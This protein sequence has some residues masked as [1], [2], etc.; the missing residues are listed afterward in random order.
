MS[1][2]WHED[3][4]GRYAQRYHD[5][6]AWTDYVSNREGVT[7]EDPR[8]TEPGPPPYPGTPTAGRT[9]ER[10][11]LGGPLA[12]IGGR[13]IDMLLVGVPSLLVSV[14]VFDIELDMETFDFE[15]FEL[16]VEV[17]VFSAIV[18]AIYETLMVGRFGRTVGKMAVGTEVVT[19]S[20]VAPSY[21]VAAVR[22]AA[23]GVLYGI[24]YLGFFLLIAA[25]V[26]VFV[27]P[28]RQTL[29]DKIASTVVA[30]RRSG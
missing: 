27:D 22:A 30:R 4:F 21:G 18:L 26:M 10:S 24:P 2:G 16:P 6:S 9:D 28:R 7:E 3:P 12:R 8:G 17:L 11:H 14:A 13:L 29:H 25:F 23:Y 5:G 15:T 20:G 19:D 1:E